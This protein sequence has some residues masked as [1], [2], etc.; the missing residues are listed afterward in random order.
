MP[1]QTTSAALG[2]SRG[3]DTADSSSSSAS[4]TKLGLGVGLGVGIPMALS[5]AGVAIWMCL[6]SRRKRRDVSG[7][8]TPVDT[9]PSYARA[10]T[11]LP[12]KGVASPEMKQVVARS[13]SEVKSE[14]S[15]QDYRP[16]L[17]GSPIA[18][19][20]DRWNAA[21]SP[22]RDQHEVEGWAPPEMGN[23]NVAGRANHWELP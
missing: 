17:R 15:E 11:S 5:L 23:G 12:R 9:H 18:S 7:D 10:E 4:A 20:S 22:V 8:P 2:G 6:R 19:V 1:I 21:S 14:L 13:S 16:E 3:S